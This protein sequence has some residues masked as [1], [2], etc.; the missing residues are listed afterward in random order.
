MVASRPQGGRGGITAVH[1]WLIVFVGL[2][3]LSTVLAVLL[4]TGRERLV[5]AAN[6]AEE[7][8]N[9][10]MRSSERSRFNV[11]L[12]QAGENR[13][14]AGVLD[15]ER[16]RLVR[17]IGFEETT[18]AAAASRQVNEL[19]EGV[20]KAVPKGVELPDLIGADLTTVVQRMQAALV[21]QAQARA[22]AEKRLAAAIQDKAG[23]IEK[24]QRQA[25]EF[26]K[27]LDGFAAQLKQNEQAT[28]QAIAKTNQ[29]LEKLKKNLITERD[30]AGEAIVRARKDLIAAQNEART[31]Q[32]ELKEIRQ[33]M[34]RFKPKVASLGL[35]AQADGKVVRAQADESLVYIDLGKDDNLTLGLRFE[36]FSPAAHLEFSRTTDATEADGDQ[37]KGSGT[38]GGAPAIA[39]KA[40]IEVVGIHELTASC[41][42]L[43]SKSSDPIVPG[44]L[45]VNVVYDPERKYRFAV[46]GRFDLDGNGMFDP[47]DT[48]K[49]KAWIKSWGGAVVELPETREAGTA[50]S[51]GLEGVDFLVMGEAPPAPTKL[52]KGQVIPPEER[53]RREALARAHERFYAV[54]RQARELSIAVLTQAQFLHFVGLGGEYERG[55]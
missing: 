10:L 42:V 29:E 13:S 52:K 40:T 54:Q 20:E 27:A 6:E 43:A 17:L 51:L 12:D 5:K 37:A 14:L 46:V 3:L 24:Q 35:A 11:F 1:V 31:L 4:Y 44:D 9:Q 33:G 19:I 16:S 32:D 38:L 21:D 34:S 15:E 49:I 8:A 48:E 7:R 39:G 28:Q 55:I 36:V 50:G 30:R 53:A 41:R 47:Q 18:S 25:E 23:A 45:I 22:D 2:W 26:K